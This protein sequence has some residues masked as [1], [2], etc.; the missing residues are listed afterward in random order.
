MFDLGTTNQEMLMFNCRRRRSL[1]LEGTQ[2]LVF[3]VL[4]GLVRK[5]WMN[6]QRNRMPLFPSEMILPFI[7]L[8]S[9]EKAASELALTSTA[10]SQYQ[11][12][13]LSSRGNKSFKADKG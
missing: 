6:M 8:L 10:M 5:I 2:Q 1:L 12:S 9:M 13:R 3:L 4:L 11:V 7:L